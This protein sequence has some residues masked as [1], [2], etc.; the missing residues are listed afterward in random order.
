MDHYST[1][2][3]MRHHF[4]SKFRH[5]PYVSSPLSPQ[6]SSTLEAAPPSSPH[7]NRR[8]LQNRPSTSA[9]STPSPANS[10][11]FSSD[12][13]IVRGPAAFQTS[14][15]DP[16]SLNDESKR[17]KRNLLALER[18]LLDDDLQDLCSPLSV[19]NHPA[20]ERDWT[21]VI[22]DLMSVNSSSFNF[23][24]TST[25]LLDQSSLTSCSSSKNDHQPT[26][27]PSS[28]HPSHSAPDSSSQLKQLLLSCATAIDEDD[29]QHSTS[30][31]AS[32]T[33]LVSKCGDPSQRLAAYM[34]DSL[35]A[36]IEQ[37]Q[38]G[39]SSKA[40]RFKDPSPAEILQGTQ[41]LYHSCPYL[42]F[43][44]MAANGAIADAFTTEPKVHI[45]DFEIGQGN[46][47][48]AL[49]G[50]FSRRPGGPPH[51]RL[52]GVGDPKSPKSPADGLESVGQRL[53]EL[54]QKVGVPFEFKALP[55]EVSQVEPWMLQNQ[56]GEALAVNFAFQL[57]HMP[58]ESVSTTNPRDRLLRMVK[59]MNPKL[60]TLVEHEAN[61]NTAP[62]YPRF[63]EALSYFT[64]VFD[65][66]ENSLSRDSRDR[67][68]A[69]QHCLARNIMN[70]VSC[71]GADRVERYELA[72][73][74][75][76]RMT[77]A[78]FRPCPLSSFINRT[79]RELLQHYSK[80]YHLRE[81]SGAL[82]LDWLNRGL[83]VASAWH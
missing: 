17:L 3:Q 55:M 10:S 21:D 16:S 49:I 45:I 60:V 4:S 19:V 67:T 77:M 73:K 24:S 82:H 74:W 39:N 58:D 81:E 52:T 35:A 41:V 56:P 48:Q 25:S 18:E 32:L 53:T 11:Y 37:L 64:A 15:T 54:A 63:V 1:P 61:T 44:Y 30:I 59:A 51:V 46:Q 36:R 71:E 33:P 75:R 27:I 47:W 38:T 78:G 72:G 57:H 34:V 8:F 12:L 70:I 83:I 7:Q 20:H 76:V 50:A 6:E 9:T 80:N 23:D 22:E 79:I 68:N 5:H 31:L 2:L 42:K 14:T 29:L 69:E 40:L 43:G 66:L 65:S 26:T 62:F 28:T 13:P